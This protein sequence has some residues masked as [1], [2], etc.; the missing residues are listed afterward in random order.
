[1]PKKRPETKTSA[2]NTSADYFLAIDLRPREFEILGQLATMGFVGQDIIFRSPYAHGGVG[3]FHVKGRFR[4]RPAVVK[5]QGVKPLIS[6][7]KMIKSFAAQNR[8]SLIRPPQV[9]FH[10]PWNHS[11]AYELIFMES[12]EG[13]FIVKEGELASPSSVSR[14]FELYRDYKKNCLT[15]PWL[16]PA[17]SDSFTQ[18]HTQ[19]D[20]MLQAHSRRGL[21]EVSDLNLI[22]RA[23]TILL[24]RYS[25][26]PSEF[27]QRHLSVN[28]FKTDTHAKVVIFSNLFWQYT[29]PLFDLTFAYSW[30]LLTIAHFSISEI[31]RQHSLW[32][33]EMLKVAKEL[34]RVEDYHFAL[35]ERSVA[36]LGLDMLMIPQE[37][38][39]LKIRPLIRSQVSSL[40][41]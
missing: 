28:D 26:T 29:Q 24:A 41:S 9:Y 14:F 3:A 11:R 15:R 23:S 36:Q 8:S 2:I 19:W 12:V 4:D 20:Q 32:Q 16:S 18:R 21:V 17:S 40:L 25:R 37:S 35:L 27:Q 10:T 5:V 22:R 38:D 13:D 30:Y 7:V 6:E 1:M 31:T 33:S 39:I 34:G